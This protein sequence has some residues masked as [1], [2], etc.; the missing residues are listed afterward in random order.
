MAKT[1]LPPS[2]KMH[3]RILFYMKWRVVAYNG[4]F[5]ANGHLIFF[6]QL[7]SLLIG[8]IY[9]CPLCFLL[10]N[11]GPHSFNYLFIYFSFI[12]VFSFQFSHSITIF[13]MFFFKILVLILSISYF[14]FIPFI[15]VFLAFNFILQSNFLLFFF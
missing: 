13:H 3:H 9:C 7:F 5:V 15:E 2:P 8:N 4:P 11:F 6:R 10:F 1:G 12:E 14:V